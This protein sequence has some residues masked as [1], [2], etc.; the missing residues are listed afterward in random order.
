VLCYKFVLVSAIRDRTKE[1][2]Q[3]FRSMASR[4]QK[5]SVVRKS[6]FLTLAEVASFRSLHCDSLLASSKASSATNMI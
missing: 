5:L 1:Q 6:Q 2:L 3:E 4:S